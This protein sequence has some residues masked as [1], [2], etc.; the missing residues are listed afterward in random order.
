MTRLYYF[1]SAPDPLTRT[2]LSELSTGN[3][4][5]HTNGNLYFDQIDSL[6]PNNRSTVVSEVASI[7]DVY[8]S[9]S[10]SD[11]M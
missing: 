1:T 10:I 6:D 9:G 4:N 8:L 2:L 5:F 3:G 7:G 11:G